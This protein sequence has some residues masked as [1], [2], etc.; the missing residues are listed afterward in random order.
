[1]RRLVIVTSV[2]IAS[3]CTLEPQ[4][5]PTAIGCY[6]LEADTIPAVYQRDMIPSPPAFVRLDTAQ[7][8]QVQVPAE[9][10]ESGPYRQRYAQVVLSRPPV[11]LIEGVPVAQSKPLRQ[12]P[13]DSIGLVFGN[14]NAFGRQFMAFLAQ[15]PT[16]EWHG[17]AELQSPHA[18]GVTH[19]VPVRLSPTSCGSER[20]AITR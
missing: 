8:G 18:Q 10:F 13:S 4:L 5:A 6:R 7:G 16:G 9:W 14:A 11:M 19:I 1:M 17:Q 3:A 15:Q 2:V 20:L 12:L